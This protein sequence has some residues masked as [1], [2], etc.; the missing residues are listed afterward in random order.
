MKFKIYSINLIFISIFTISINSVF[1]DS[2][3]V[4]ELQNV[5]TVPIISNLEIDG[6]NVQEICPAN[7]CEIELTNNNSSFNPPNLNNMTI[8]HII[9]FNLKYNNKNVSL[10]PTKKEYLEKFRE[11]MNSC[12]IYDIIE[13]KG[14]KIYF[15]SDETNTM[16]RISDSKSWHYDS[17]GIYD[18]I[19]NTYTV[20]GDLIDNFTN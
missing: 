2:D 8:S 17:I 20:K 4:L 16:S 1:G 12:S 19:K 11:T 13:D 5:N 9:D 15:C 6:E 7:N 14:R 10:D 18:A 3:F